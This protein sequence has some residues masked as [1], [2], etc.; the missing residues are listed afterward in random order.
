MEKQY[1]N[2]DVKALAEFLVQ[3]QLEQDGSAK[4]LATAMNEAKER[5][6]YHDFVV[7]AQN[8]VDGKEHIFT[9]ND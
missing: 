1:T 7:R 4:L 3:Y 9:F 2:E 5:I 8:S 6:I